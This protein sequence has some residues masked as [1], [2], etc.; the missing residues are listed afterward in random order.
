MTPKERAQ[1]LKEALDDAGV[2]GYGRLKKLTEVIGVSKPTAQGWLRGALPS[3][4]TQFLTVCDMYNIDP[5]EWVFGESKKTTT[6][7][8]DL[9]NVLGA[10][11][12]FKEKRDV[13]L[14]DEQTAKLI[15]IMLEEG[16]SIVSR[17]TDL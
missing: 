14:T 7:V 6:Q 4:A 3:D 16:T 11:S 9:A 2:E 5:H 15:L 12:A 8:Q 17:L 1:F 13:N 10:V